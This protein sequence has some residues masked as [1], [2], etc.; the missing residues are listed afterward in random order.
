LIVALWLLLLLFPKEISASNHLA[1]TTAN[2]IAATAT[3]TAAVLVLCIESIVMEPRK[4]QQKQKR[5]DQQPGT[6]QDA[7]EDAPEDEDNT[8]APGAGGQ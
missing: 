8:T 6:G 3:A 7:S 1:V 4:C 5:A 2:T